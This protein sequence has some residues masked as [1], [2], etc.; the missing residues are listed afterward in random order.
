MYTLHLY[1]IIRFCDLHVLY[2]PLVFIYY[3]I[4]IETKLVCT[5]HF[6][7]PNG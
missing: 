6:E 3:K 1:G 4:Q 2:M 7:L 5:L